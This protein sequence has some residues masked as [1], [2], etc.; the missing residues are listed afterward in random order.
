MKTL[1]LYFDGISEIP[2]LPKGEQIALGRSLA[3]ARRRFSLA[4]ALLPGAGSALLERARAL[5]ATGRSMASLVEGFRGP[6]GVARDHEFSR[7]LKR[8]EVQLAKDAS[9][10]T[11]AREILGAGVALAVL[12][13]IWQADRQRATCTHSDTICR[14][15]EHADDAHDRY[16]EL[17]AY[18]TYHNLRLVVP[19]AKRFRHRGIEFLDLIQEGN[20]A[21]MRAVEKYDPDRGHG[22][23]SYAVWWIE[24]ALIRAVGSHGNTIRIPTHA[25]QQKRRFLDRE[26]VLR[27]ASATEPTRDEIKRA[28][29]ACGKKGGQID[30]TL[31]RIVSADQPVRPL[32]GKTLVES[33]ADKEAAPPSEL[34][35]VRELSGGVATELDALSSREKQ[36]LEWRFGF[37]GNDEQ[38]LEAIGRRFGLS[39]ERVRQI[40]KSALERLRGR[41]AI[42]RLAS[43]MGIDL[44]QSE[45]DDN[46]N[47]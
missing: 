18:F 26:R 42:R 17:R 10:R 27:C 25:Y 35:S 15:L 46:P 4:V 41:G 1:D 21:L 13:E 34:A 32:D 47:G 11:I 6:G 39:R 16:V 40:E 22:F 9:P 45:G 8:L 7:R 5:D 14:L 19:F 12:E 37:R 23:A 2:V 30:A 36:V 28:L 38:S 3:R 29:G 20:K 31:T 33:I 44:G 24:Q 43:D